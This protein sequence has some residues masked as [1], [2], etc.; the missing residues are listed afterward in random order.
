LI[1]GDHLIISDPHP[2]PMSGSAFNE[3]KPFTQANEYLTKE[4]RGAI[5]WQ[6][7]P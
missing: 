6:I 4:G 1:E 2:S 3:T 5:D 7:S